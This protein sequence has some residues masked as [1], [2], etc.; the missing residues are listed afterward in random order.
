MI[1]LKLIENSIRTGEKNKFTPQLS[2]LHLLTSAVEIRTTTV[3]NADNGDSE[4]MTQ[5]KSKS[6]EK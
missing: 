6:P 2:R 3:V 5:K 4:S 1:I